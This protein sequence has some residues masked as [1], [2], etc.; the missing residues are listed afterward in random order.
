MTT[1]L[2]STECNTFFDWQTLAIYNSFTRIK[3]RNLNLVRMMACDDFENYEDPLQDIVETF[4]HENLRYSPIVHEKGYSPYN[5]LY[6]FLKY[7]EIFKDTTDYIVLT[8]VDSIIRSNIIPQDLGV[9][10]GVVYT[11][12]YEHLIG[13]DNNFYK[14]FLVTRNSV[15]KVGKFQIFHIS[16]AERIA[17]LWFEYTK[18]IREFIH[19]KTELYIKETVLNNHPN[20]YEINQAKWHADMYGYIFAASHLNIKHIIS[21]S[22]LINAGYSPHVQKKP[23]ISHYGIEFNIGDT[24]FD[25]IHYKDMKISDCKYYLI[26]NG[27]VDSNTTKRDMISIEVINNINLGLCYYYEKVCEMACST[28]T[29][30]KINNEINYIEKSWKCKNEHPDCNIWKENGECSKNPQFMNNLCTYSCGKCEKEEY[31]FDYKYTLFI[32]FTLI[33]IYIIFYKRK[34]EVKY[35]GFQHVV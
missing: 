19:E 11:A 34:N 7:L 10:P 28:Q 18:L 31:K 29:I 6:G 21:Q 5:K 22:F 26:D 17:P 14:R 24:V 3:N 13:A 20:E 35:K 23:Y 27:D 1:I 12:P 30:E 32:I 15:D 33:I 9:K 4:V 2:F 8:D 16:D 25:K